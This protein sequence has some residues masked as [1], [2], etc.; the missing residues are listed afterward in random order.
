M[1]DEHEERIRELL[2]IQRVAQRISSILDLDRLLEEI[3][4]DVCRTFG[5]SRSTM[6]LK[7]D[8]TNELVMHGWTGPHHSEG[9][10][11][12]I[13]V[14]GIVGHVGVTMETYYAPNVLVD[15]YYRLSEEQSRSEVAIP[16]VVGGRLVGI[17][18]VEHTE[19]DA[20]PPAR[21]Q[22][23]EALAGHLATAVENARLFRQERLEKERMASELQEARQIQLGL[24]PAD[25][26][27][28]PGFA[29]EAQCIPCYEVGGDWFDF[30][31][32][33]DGRL[34]IILADVSG[35]GL[36]AALLMSSTRSILRLLAEDGLPPRELLRRIN[37]TLL[38]D[39]P[40]ARFVTMIYA[41]LD[42]SNRRLVF[43]N[44]GHPYPLLVDSAGGRFLRTDAGFPLGLRDGSF[45]EREV[46]LPPGSRLVLYSD[47][48]PE[49]TS[50]A[51][52][53]YGTDRI[54]RHLDAP[55]A[56]VES[57]LDDVRTFVSG[58]PPSDDQTVVLIRATG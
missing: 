18:D 33:D 32:L 25:A 5:Y 15:P 14:D 20:F 46:E 7:D 16:L 52:E 56:T 39:L 2:L 19:V 11:F 9:D 51:E 23:L 47:G 48:L 57:L 40:I 44:A 49:A 53:E 43:A 30:L 22:L 54:R 4:T 1:H 28:T 6:W 24:F 45:A 41:V 58:A 34:G 31:R 55:G 35:K 13:G 38:K 17:F 26:P 10:R 12:R 8:A 27:E 36:A 42:A 37:R 21:I 29:I 3:L 50:G